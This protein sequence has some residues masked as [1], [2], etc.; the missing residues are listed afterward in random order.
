M[1]RKTKNILI[2]KFA[3]DANFKPQTLRKYKLNKKAIR[4]FIYFVFL[5]KKKYLKCKLNKSEMKKRAAR[6]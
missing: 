1:T 5:F 4:K 6:F 2:E 3:Y